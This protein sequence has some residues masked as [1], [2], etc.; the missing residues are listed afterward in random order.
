MTVTSKDG[1]LLGTHYL[2]STPET[3]LW[4]HLPGERDLPVARML[5]GETITIDTVSHEGILPDQGRDPRDFFA[6]F[7]VPATHVL[8]D[9][10]D[11][12]GSDLLQDTSCGPHVVT[13]PIAVSGAQPGDLLAMTVVALSRRADYGI[14]SSR[15]GKGALPE[16]HPA[17][18]LTSVF[19]RARGDEGFLPM[20]QNESAY[21]GDG[22]SIRFPLRP[23]LGIMGVAP[24]GA[25]RINS[26][27]PGLYGGNL[28]I[29]SLGVG[30]TLYVPVQVPDAMAYIGDP[31]FAQG[32]G[33]VALTAFEAPLRATLLFDIV[34]QAAGQASGRPFAET[35]ELLISIGLDADLDEAARESVRGALDLVEHRYAVPRELAYAY[36]SAAADVRISQVV[37]QVKGAHTHIR[38]ADFR[39]L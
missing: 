15:H 22:A 36:L 26:V 3:V 28:D 11:I 24:A 7:G 16:E 2:P 23:F 17:S 34:P 12:A 9:A 31:H 13:G 33:E 25:A 37:D 8:P 30:S 14:I 18:A 1:A 32:D 10:V 20:A 27:P 4:G 6:R 35:D 5:P 38:K 19:C 29:T 21:S 39:E